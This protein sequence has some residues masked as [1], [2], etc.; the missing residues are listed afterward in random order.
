MSLDLLL[1]PNVWLG[2][3]YMS[4]IYTDNID[5]TN[6][7]G[8][9]NIGVAKIGSLGRI[10][11]G[12]VG[13]P[14]YIDDVLFNPGLMGGYSA[15]A[16]IA[17]TDNNGIIVDNT[18]H[19]LKLQYA[20]ST[21][22]GILSTAA[23]TIPGFKTFASGLTAGV[24]TNTFFGTTAGNL[25]TTGATNV[26]IGYNVLGQLTNGSNNTV[27][28]PQSLNQLTT[29]TN[30]VTMGRDSGGTITTGTRNIC[31]GYE[32]GYNL[33]TSNSRNILIGSLGVVGDNNITRIGNATDSIGTSKCFIQ[34]ISGVTTDGAAVACLVDANGQLG[35][36]SSERKLKEN[37]EPLK[38][39]R[40][41]VK[42]LKPC[43]FNMI[44]DESKTKT[45]GFIADEF[46][47]I[48]PEYVVTQ[49]NGIRTIQYHL[50]STLYL[51]EI[52]RLQNVVESLQ[53]Q[54]NEI[55]YR[56]QANNI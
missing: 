53:T 27:I 24:T 29:G 10:N 43:S 36:I 15:V 11:I 32:A 56:M 26:G 4:T 46:E 39:V 6:F 9:L 7:N 13:V 50:L 3:F 8:T 44:S 31:I 54:I 47:E 38:D 42:N 12:A 25:T 28:G 34:G 18:L 5:S 33:N 55:N 17:A 20:S 40:D 30:N 48:A 19:Q 1:T 22:P 41:I 51:K 21:R 45:I 49:A 2:P 16:P 52:Q 14:V 37:I 23:Q 35:T